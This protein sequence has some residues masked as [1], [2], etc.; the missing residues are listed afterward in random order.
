MPGNPEG[1]ER[2]VGY[3]L[4]FFYSIVVA[5]LWI[6]GS[7]LRGAARF[8]AEFGA[9]SWPR[10]NGSVAGGNVKAI[11]GWVVDYAVGELD[12]SYI[13]DG[14]YYSGRISRQYP[15]EQ[16]AW[17]FVDAHRDQPVIVRYRDRAA[18]KSVLLLQDQDFSWGA[19]TE[20]SLRA[21]VWQHWTDELRREPV[22]DTEDEDSLTE[23]EA[24]NATS[25]PQ[26]Q[27][28]AG[29]HKKTSA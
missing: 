14:E 13:V 27:S 21:A 11:H 19:R 20:P 1:A 24:G 7:L 26:G 3:I 16:A 4:A 5:L 6:P 22:A 18:Q 25:L 28:V 12:Y 17:D 23:N 9:D 10:A 2:G 8:C 29:S 15:D